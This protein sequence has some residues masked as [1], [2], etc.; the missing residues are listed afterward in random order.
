M[1]SSPVHYN[2][3]LVF[4]EDVLPIPVQE[5]GCGARVKR[6]YNGAATL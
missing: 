5:A 6:S 1:A 4:Q 2:K 3:V